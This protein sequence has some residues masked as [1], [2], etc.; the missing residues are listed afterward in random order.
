MLQPYADDDPC[1][2]NDHGLGESLNSF[3]DQDEKG[4]DEACHKN[5]PC[6]GIPWH[7][8]GPLNQVSGFFRNI[9]VPDDNQMH[10][11]EIPPEHTECKKELADIM[12]T[13]CRQRKVHLWMQMQQGCQDDDCPQSYIKRLDESIGSEKGGIS[14]RIHTHHKIK[15]DQRKHQGES[16]NIQVAV[17]RHSSAIFAEIRRLLQPAAAQQAGNAG[18]PAVRRRLEPQR[19]IKISKSQCI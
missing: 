18:T 1:T 3:I 11:K 6:Q 12:E 14:V 15:A 8:Q 4:K 2:D 9:A 17:N 13:G 16:Q 7:G 19:M 10:I 5:R